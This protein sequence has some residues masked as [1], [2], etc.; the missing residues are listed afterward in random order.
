[1]QRGSLAVVLRGRGLCTL[2]WPRGSFRFHQGGQPLSTSL[3]LPARLSAIHI[4][5][6]RWVMEKPPPPRS[7]HGIISDKSASHVL[8][9]ASSALVYVKRG[10]VRPYPYLA[11]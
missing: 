5:C 7:L 11:T 9:G 4:L 10:G 8:I 3:L 6:D 2:R 1:M